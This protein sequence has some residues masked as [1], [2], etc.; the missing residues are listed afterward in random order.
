MGRTCEGWERR[1]KDQILRRSSA[2]R[3]V[4]RWNSVVVA[5]FGF[6]FVGGEGGP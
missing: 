2:G 1:V 5:G 3:W 6:G 4:K